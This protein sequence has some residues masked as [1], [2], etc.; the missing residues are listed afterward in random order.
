MQQAIV[1]KGRLVGPKTVE[2]DE[3]VSEASAEVEVVV[4]LPGKAEPAEE[5]NVFEFL[6]RLPPGTRTKADID[7]QIREE[8]DAWDDR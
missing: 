7:R 4:L 6:R 3:A 5:E 2:L 8:R 1:V